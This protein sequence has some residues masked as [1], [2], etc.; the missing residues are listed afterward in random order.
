MPIAAAEPLSGAR[1]AIRQS[2]AA[3]SYCLSGCRVS[4]RRACLQSDGARVLVLEESNRIGT[5]VCLTLDDVP[6]TA[7]GGGQQVLVNLK[8]RKSLRIEDLGINV[9]DIRRTGP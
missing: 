1:R 5:V 2:Y 9:I 7:E 6:W 8:A 3:V 4:M